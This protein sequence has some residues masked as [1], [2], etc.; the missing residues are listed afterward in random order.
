[1]FELSYELP[2]DFKEKFE[3]MIAT[4]MEGMRIPGCSIAMVKDDQVI[5]AR[6]FGARNVKENLPATPDT[7]YGIGSCTKSFTALAI[8]Q[9]AEEKKLDVHDPVSK[10]LPFKLG[11]EEKPIQIHHLLSMS[12]GIPN[13]GVAS[14]L[15]NKYTGDD[16][17]W[18]PLS[19]I[20]DLFL[21]VN[22]AKEEIAE[23]PGQRMFYFNTGYTLLG[24]I[25]ERVSGMPYEDYIGE[26]ILRPLKM[27]RSTF[28]MEDCAKDSD[29]MTAYRTEKKEETVKITPSQH[30]F[31]KFIYA[32][33]GLLSSVNE[34]TN[35]LIA[36]MNRGIFE[37][38]RILGS[39]FM[40]ELHK[41]QFESD[42]FRFYLGDYG[43]IGYGYGW[44]VAEAFFGHKLVTHGGSTG[45]SS[46]ELMFV[47][48]LKIGIAAAA[49]V[50]QCPIPVLK[51]ALA[52]LM[53]K[54]PEKDIPDFEIDKRLG[55][56]TGKYAIYKGIHEVSILKKG[57]M[58]YLEAK[59]GGTE[60]SYPLIPETDKIENYN[61]FA[62]VG[63]GKKQL[64]EF[65]VE[66]PDE[67]D[68]YLE[69]NRFHK[70]KG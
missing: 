25:V 7:L 44:M 34:L 57:A 5:Y 10:H 47:P 70:L 64:V 55:M 62:I 41:I 21:H 28:L 37:G 35:Y 4:A 23:E 26:K 32:P 8:M 19:S 33:G 46:A 43:N 59:F 29:V 22:G 17:K 65:V 60:I 3:N 36:N 48:D 16:E 68:L 58:L 13:L 11:S 50:G 54:D 40:D 38:T 15:I 24:E 52:F 42:D 45:V 9:L 31:D 27:R 61:F 53:G 51:G 18:V 20:E 49:N 30:P 39:S 6:G 67:I 12:S 14:I 69:R 1:M 2:E 66:S 63:P 56:L